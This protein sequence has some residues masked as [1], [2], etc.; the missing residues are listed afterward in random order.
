MEELEEKKEEM[1]RIRVDIERKISD[2]ADQLLDKLF[3]VHIKDI[4]KLRETYGIIVDY[5]LP[6]ISLVRWGVR[7]VECLSPPA[8]GCLWILAEAAAD[9]AL[10]KLAETCWFQ[11]KIQPILAKVK[12]VTTD[13]PNMLGDG[14]IA[15][16]KGILPNSLQDIFADLESGEV[17]PTAA[18]TGCDEDD[19][20]TEYH[21]HPL[22]SQID[23]LYLKIGPDRAAAMGQLARKMSAAKDRPLTAEELT[24]LGDELLKV[25]PEQLQKYAAQY[26]GGGDG[27]PA[28]L[29]KVIDQLNQTPAPGAAAT[30][31][32]TTPTPAPP[33]ATPPDDS[34]N[35]SKDSG[36]G[37]KPPDKADDKPSGS[38]AGGMAVV[39]AASRV[40]DTL[41]LET[42]PDVKGQV[43]NPSSAH[44]KGTEP[45]IDVLVWWKN[46]A[47]VLVRNVDTLVTRRPLFPL[48]AKSLDD[49]LAL[50]VKYKVK[51]TYRIDEVP[52]AFIGKNQELTGRIFTSL[53]Q[54]FLEERRKQHAAEFAKKK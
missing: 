8:F 40:V 23:A 12:Y 44:T 25:N 21:E 11:E 17:V 28:D 6:L 42:R 2:T 47:R 22:H 50:D 33:P 46:E 48:T 13:L 14:I 10:Q 27:V 19:D 34:T 41:P 26:P 49:A 15:K 5:V 9:F 52:G 30:G 29:T 39:D 51:Y 35:M 16:L 24:K 32:T 37:T 45:K 20:H 38:D 54:Q 18:E 3:G 53:G 43:T 31:T 1:E 4:E 36:G 7:V